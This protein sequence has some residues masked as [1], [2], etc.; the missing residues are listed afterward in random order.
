M[1]HPALR[2][3]EQDVEHPV[4]GLVIVGVQEPLAVEVIVDE[5]AGYGFAVAGGRHYIPLF[6]IPSIDIPP[7][8]A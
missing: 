2:L 5:K 1:G 8:A 4:I 6:N 3:F 7:A